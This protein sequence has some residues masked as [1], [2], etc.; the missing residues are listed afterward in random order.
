MSNTSIAH[1]S[2]KPLPEQCQRVLERLWVRNAER[3]QE[4]KSL[5]DVRHHYEA[6]LRLA[7][8][9]KV[10]VDQHLRSPARRP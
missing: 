7:N 6:R 9:V 10:G 8:S 3:R 1:N 4:G 5:L 2:M